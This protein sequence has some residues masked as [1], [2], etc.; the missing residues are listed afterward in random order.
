MAEWRNRKCEQTDRSNCISA[1]GSRGSAATTARGCLRVEAGRPIAASEDAAL[2]VAL[3]QLKHQ[4]IL[5][6]V[7]TPGRDMIEFDAHRD[8][9]RVIP[10]RGQAGCTQPADDQCYT[11]NAMS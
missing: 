10:T 3:S 7:S 1:K 4:A 2:Q 11:P 8:T 5:V 9:T 6:G